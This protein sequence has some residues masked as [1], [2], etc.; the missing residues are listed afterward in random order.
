MPKTLAIFMLLS[1]V[2]KSQVLYNHDGAKHPHMTKQDHEVGA[3]VNEQQ[4]GAPSDYLRPVVVRCHPDSMQVIVQA[5]MFNTGL[6]VDTRHLRLGMEDLPKKEGPSPCRAVLSGPNEYTI[7][8]HLMDCGT[9]KLPPTEEKI[10]YSNLLVFSPEP[11]SDGLLRLDGATVPIECHFDK[12][13]SVSGISLLPTWMPFVQ[14]GTAE[15]QIIF[16][17]RLLTEDWQF[18]RGAYTY[19]LGDPIH[20]EVSS[21]LGNHKPLRVFVD[22][23]VAT[24]TPDAEA[25]LRYDFIDH[26][27]CLAD[28]YLTNSTSR[29]LSRAEDHR[30]RFQLDAF[31]F[32]QENTNQV[33]ITCHLTAVPLLVNIKSQHRACSFIENSWRSADGNNEDC[34]SCGLPYPVKEH[35]TKSLPT[36]STRVKSQSPL[37]TLHDLVKNT[38]QPKPANYFH[39]GPRTHQNSQTTLKLSNRLMREGETKEK[40]LKLGPLI[41]L[42]SPRASNFTRERSQTRLAIVR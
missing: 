30:V 14:R 39:I 20:F 42:P 26:Y 35:P 4:T 12:F 6:N 17:L 32:Y 18:E 33:Y 15:D 41:I 8:A 29:F 10:I 3:H 7:H 21:F 27:G 25:A 16:S 22:H 9:V 24:A 1:T 40:T 34:R 11:S 28:A 23:C 31:K 5:D 37:S 13:Y 38:P 2:T 36:T 19:Y